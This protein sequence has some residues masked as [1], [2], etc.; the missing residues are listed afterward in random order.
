ML[1][2]NRCCA[3][4]II[5]IEPSYKAIGVGAGY[6]YKDWDFSVNHKIGRMATNPTITSF[7]FTDDLNKIFS[8]SVGIAHFVNKDE[9]K[10]YPD[11]NMLD[12]NK[13]LPIAQIS[14]GYYPKDFIRAFVAINYCKIVWPSIGLR[15]VL[16]FKKT[17]NEF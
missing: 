17:R 11:G 4:V 13:W 1:A 8:A 10:F 5:K 2:V 9:N 3:Q 14:A 7:L 12:I 16:N 15:A 6:K